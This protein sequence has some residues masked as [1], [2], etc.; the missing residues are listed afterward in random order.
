MP[1]PIDP[2]R[3]AARLARTVTYDGAPCGR[4]HSGTRYVSTAACLDCVK[5]RDT[6]RDP[7][8]RPERA[9]DIFAELLG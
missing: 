8:R 7:R 3:G 9:A 4:G 5:A 6:E 2:A 1:R